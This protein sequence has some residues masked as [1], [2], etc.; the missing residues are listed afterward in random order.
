[1]GYLCGFT[2]Y[3]TYETIELRRTAPAGA[4]T[5]VRWRWIWRTFNLERVGPDH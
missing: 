2:V 4:I 1:M 3:L 5:G